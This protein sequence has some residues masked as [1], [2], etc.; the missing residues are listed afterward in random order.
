MV[1]SKKAKFVFILLILF[2]LFV[3]AKRRNIFFYFVRG[4]ADVPRLLDFNKEDSN[5]LRPLILSSDEEINIKVF[6]RVKPAV[7]NIVTTTLTLNFWMEVVPQK[8][9]GS[10]VIIDHNGYILTNN[11][12]VARA[13]KITVTL[14]D[15]RKVDA[16]LVGRD[17]DSDIAVIKIPS[18][19]VEAVAVLGDSDTLKCGQKVIAIGN[20]FG[21][22]HT[23]TT[24]VISA[25]DRDIVTADGSRLEGLIQTDAA[26]NPGNSGGPLLNSAGEVIGI[27]TAIYT[28]SGG[29]QGIGFAIPINREKEIATQL[30]MQGR[31]IRPWLGI[32]GITVTKHISRTLGLGTD[33]GVLVVR[34]IDSSPADQAGIRGG[35][36][37]VVID[38][39]RFLAGG[40]VITAIEEYEI[41]SVRQLKKV[42]AKM[43]VGQTV[44]VRIYRDG[45]PM[46]IDVTLA[47][48]PSMEE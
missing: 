5:E 10:G 39:V 24:G 20:P 27:N 9:Q 14:A 15:G 44:S 28:T 35:N 25:L 2:C 7:V 42:L 47:E 22:S 29:Y 37:E 38:G 36:K 32:C 21:L 34:V 6:E 17:P 33:K 4:R 16:K 43:K 31:V 26:I 41:S 23:L 12:V 18:E 3:W 40:D 13:Q 45:M 1:D 19:Y 11:H 46:E 30:V 8:G 48:R